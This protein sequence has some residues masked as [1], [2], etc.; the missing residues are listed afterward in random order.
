MGIQFY[1]LGF[2]FK[3]CIIQILTEIDRNP[4]TNVLPFFP[5][6]WVKYVI[7]LDLNTFSVILPGATE[8]TRWNHK[9]EFTLFR[10]SHW[11]QYT[12]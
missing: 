6:S 11:F 8:P 12:R 2:I 5:Q 10:V 1:V 4:V 3:L 7:A 9:A